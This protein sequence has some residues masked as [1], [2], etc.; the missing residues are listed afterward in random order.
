MK[1]ITF[2]LNDEYEIVPKKV[3]LNLER[4]NGFQLINNKLHLYEGDETWIKTI[5]LDQK[6]LDKFMEL[7]IDFLNPG[8]A[9]VFHVDV[10]VE[11]IK[12]PKGD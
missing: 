12:K 2:A 5:D 10:C 9:G 6:E 4:V 3:F 8:Y 7:L 11:H 1:W